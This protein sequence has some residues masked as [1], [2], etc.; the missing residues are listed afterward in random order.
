MTNRYSIFGN[1]DSDKRR[2][3]DAHRTRY[4][5]ALDLAS[6]GEHSEALARYKILLSLPDFPYDLQA[7]ALNDVGCIH[8][9]LENWALAF[10]FL[11][12]S[13]EKDSYHEECE[14]NL[15][16]LMT[17]T[18]FLSA[19]NR[20]QPEIKS[21]LKHLRLPHGRLATVDIRE[22][23]DEGN[24]AQ[25]AAFL[26]RAKAEDLVVA[27]IGTAT[28]PCFDGGFDLR[29]ELSSLAQIAVLMT[30]NLHGGPEKRDGIIAAIFDI[31][32]HAIESSHYCAPLV[33]SV[34]QPPL[35]QYPQ[36]T[37][38]NHSPFNH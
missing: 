33:P 1:F 7:K 25:V 31:E 10:E 29:D 36:L 28:A 14:A 3:Q 21:C 26:K 24:E 30:S 35:I 32:F 38:A 23:V 2:R 4:E 37:L 8:F 18:R 15:I 27:Q 20:C 22:S 17:N 19:L 16:G 34:E 6:L 11:L 9:V 12:L 5:K 13:L